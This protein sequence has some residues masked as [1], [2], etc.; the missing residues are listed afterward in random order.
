MSKHRKF[1]TVT[2]T[3]LTVC[4]TTT[5]AFTPIFATSNKTYRALHEEPWGGAGPVTRP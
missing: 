2:T 1:A 4:T 5:D 3:L